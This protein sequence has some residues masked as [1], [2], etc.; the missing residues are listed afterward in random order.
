MNIYCKYLKF[1]G[2]NDIHTW[3]ALNFMGEITYTYFQ[4]TLENALNFMGEMTCT[5]FPKTLANALKFMGE[6]A[7]TKMDITMK[8]FYLD[9]F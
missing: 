6:M 3:F 2:I 9:L 4:K 1:Y 5:W 8:N 7:C